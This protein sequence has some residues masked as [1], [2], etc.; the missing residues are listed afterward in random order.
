M[1]AQGAPAGIIAAVDF[2][3]RLQ[4]GMA[5]DGANGEGLRTEAPA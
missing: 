3:R 2:A 5:H 1:D 4:G